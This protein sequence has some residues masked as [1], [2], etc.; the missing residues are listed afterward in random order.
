MEFSEMQ[1]CTRGCRRQVTSYRWLINSHPCDIGSFQRGGD[2][3]HIACVS[4]MK[5]C[6]VCKNRF[7]QEHSDREV[8]LLPPVFDSLS[9]SKKDDEQMQNI[10]KNLLGRDIHRQT[11]ALG[12]INRAITSTCKTDNK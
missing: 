3:T 5:L 10:K 2:L 12:T 6:R 1:T 4:C 8:V 9:Q 11:T 7:C